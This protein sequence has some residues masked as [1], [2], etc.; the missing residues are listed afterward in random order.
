MLVD[1]DFELFDADLS[2]AD[3]SG[4]TIVSGDPYGFRLGRADLS[5][6]N[7]RNAHLVGVELQRAV[8]TN[9]D[10]TGATLDIPSLSGA[11]SGG[12]LYGNLDLSAAV[13]L[14]TMEHIGRSTIGVDTL[15]NSELTH[16]FNISRSS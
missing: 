1:K 10:F 5:H 15:R 11:V 12:T 9:A 6:A 3:F 16:R 8:L 4:S 13:G 7:F 2:H 14:D